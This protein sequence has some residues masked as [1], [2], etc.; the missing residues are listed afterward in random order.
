VLALLPHRRVGD[1]Q[2][3][4]AAANKLVGLEKS[5]FSNGASSDFL[6]H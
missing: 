2:H 4:I 1:H 3:R 5:C 6:E